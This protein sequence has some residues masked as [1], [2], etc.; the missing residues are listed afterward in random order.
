MSIPFF[1][2][3][4]QTQTVLSSP[5]PKAPESEKILQWQ[6]EDVAKWLHSIGFEA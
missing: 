6:K 2:A 1:L 5:P 4:M 3:V